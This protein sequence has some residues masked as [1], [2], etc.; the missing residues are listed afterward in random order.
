MEE[1]LIKEFPDIGKVKHDIIYTAID[2]KDNGLLDCS[3]SLEGLKEKIN[4]FI[5]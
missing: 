1:K 2:K 5:K 3:D 4:Y